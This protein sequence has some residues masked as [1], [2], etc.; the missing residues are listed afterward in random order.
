MTRDD[1]PA[2]R[3]EVETAISLMVGGI[4]EENT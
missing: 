4:P 2:V 1:D 3:V